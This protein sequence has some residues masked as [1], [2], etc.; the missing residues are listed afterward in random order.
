MLF[1]LL[2]AAAHLASVASAQEVSVA[3]SS[4]MPTYLSLAPNINEFIRFADGGPDGNWYVGYNNAWIV[5]LP[6]APAG[7]FSHAYI[8]AKV[9]RAKTR[10]NPNKPWL[11]ERLEGRLYMGLAQSPAFS[12]EQSFFLVDAVDLPLEGDA[13]SFAEGIGASD[14][15]W[16]EVP[17][18]LVSFKQPNYLIIWSPSKYFVRASSSPILAGAAVEDAPEGGEAHAWNNHSIVG[19]PPRSPSGALET[20]LNNMSPGL[21]IKLVPNAESEVSVGDFALQRVGKR[22]VVQFSVAGT[23]ISEAWIETSRDQLDWT[24]ASHYRRMQPFIF[25]LHGEK[26]TPGTFLRAVARDSLGKVGYSDA[27]GIPYAPH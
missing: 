24:R 20:P 18:S 2:F 5:K 8:G 6:A 27:I 3:T 4:V 19:V 11:R 10:A 9:G 1:S 17:L 16:T 21:A 25:S 26:L 22:V 12:S 13:Q 23:D 14:W 15:F 7:D